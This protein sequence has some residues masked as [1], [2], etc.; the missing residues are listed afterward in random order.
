[1]MG[2]MKQLFL[3][4]FL[5][6]AAIFSLASSLDA[7]MDI[8]DKLQPEAL[9]HLQFSDDIGLSGRSAILDM[10]DLKRMDILDVL[11]LISQKS[12]LNI[13][14]SENVKGQVTVFLRNI[15]AEKALRIIVETYGW[16]YVQE[17]NILRVM[18]DGDYKEKYGCHFGQNIL[19]E[20][21]TLSYAK[22]ET[23]ASKI[24]EMI[25]PSSGA[26]KFDGRSNR[27]MVSGTAEKID[28]VRSLIEAFDKKDREVLIEAKIVQVVLSDDYKLGIDWEAVVADMHSLNL[29]S[30]FNIPR[31]ILK[32]GELRVGTMAADGYTVL[33]EALETVGQTEI[34][35]SPRVAAINNK[36]AKILVGSTQPYVTTTTTTPSS[37]PT[38][39]AESV[40]FIEV[41]VKLFVTPTIHE[42]DFITMAIRPEVS[43]VVS[44]VTTSNNNT[45]PVV[46]TSEAETTVLVKNETTVVI[47]GLIKNEK[48][49]TIDKVPIL[50]DF[51]IFGM[52]FRR[53]NDL[54]RKTEIVIFLTPKI[55]SG[56][57]EGE[58]QRAAF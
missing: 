55:I 40:S 16:A 4:A 27:I 44:N 32:K 26:V 38:T 52:A 5:V 12:G 13:I 28:E 57:A 35:S 17:G 47:G 41:G 56:E 29:K 49:E 45:I 6:F 53:K 20:T 9:D 11:R 25:T 54:V 24:L 7:K 1:M 42:D 3:K 50:G 39:T 15:D 51:P 22:A 31:D 10:L 8:A 2:G 48:I 37:G 34:L 21:F 58:E 30:N 14:A 43:S 36:E 33:V 18:T 19:T 46:E 23:I